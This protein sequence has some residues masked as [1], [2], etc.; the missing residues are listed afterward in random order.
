MNLDRS[1]NSQHQGFLGWYLTGRIDASGRDESLKVS[2]SGRNFIRPISSMMTRACF[3]IYVGTTTLGIEGKF[4]V[5]ALQPS[6]LT[7]IRS[8]QNSSS[9]FVGDFVPPLLVSI[10][11]VES[12]KFILNLQPHVL[13]EVA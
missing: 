11:S 4:S 7:T 13:K 3:S 10:L 1:L 5:D 6:S 9:R 12:T 8:G 2:R